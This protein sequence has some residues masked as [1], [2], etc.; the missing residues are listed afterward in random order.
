MPSD[1]APAFHNLW[2][3]ANLTTSV[4]GYG[5]GYPRAWK[6]ENLRLSA[7]VHHKRSL[8]LWGKEDQRTEAATMATWGGV[9]VSC[10]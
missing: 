4:P 9:R 3:H 5:N 7:I 6:G 8:D 2:V 10:W 1:V